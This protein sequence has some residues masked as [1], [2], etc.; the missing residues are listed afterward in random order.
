[1]RW[2]LAILGLFLL[3]PQALTQQPAM[4]GG[5][6]CVVAK[7]L[8]NSEA[9]EWSVGQPSVSIAIETAKA[10]L[11]K[12]GFSYVFPQANSAIPHGWLAV[13]KTAYRTFTGKVRTSYGCGLSAI[14]AKDAEELATIDLRAYSWGWKPNYGYEIVE[15]I[16][17]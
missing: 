14:S 11:Q 15:I 4:T 17:Y 5:A 3:V 13:I 10:A 6:A 1:M 2:I 7:K 9:I 12:K 8:G 16:Q